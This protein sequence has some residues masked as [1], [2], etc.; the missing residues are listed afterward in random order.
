MGQSKIF[1]A[2]KKLKRAG[3]TPAQSPPRPK[4]LSKQRQERIS[5][6]RE[7]LKSEHWILFRLTIIATRGLR[8]EQCG[9]V[10]GKIHLH[11]LSY[12][13]L[14]KELESDVRLLCAWCHTKEHGMNPVVVG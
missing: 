2:W 6:Y 9:T 12:E 7:Y 14:G 8:C 10:R 5:K 3:L 13:R 4:K 11:H 1:K